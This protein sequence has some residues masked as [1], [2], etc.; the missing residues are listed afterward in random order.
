LQVG[1]V[2]VLGG[3]VE[4]VVFGDEGFKLGLDVCVFVSMVFVFV[5]VFVSV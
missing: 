2:A 4:V 5:F 1:A 3:F